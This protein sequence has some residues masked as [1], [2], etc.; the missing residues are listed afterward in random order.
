M[1][2]FKLCKIL[3]PVDFSPCSLAGVHYAARLAKTTGGTL[4]LLHVIFPYTQL[5]TTDRG[6]ADLIRL[7]TAAKATA[8][9]QMKELTKKSF[10]GD[11][12]CETEIRTGSVIDE[13]VEESSEPGV[14][15]IVTSTHG[16]TGLERAVI[17]SVAEHVVR[18]AECPVL[19]V[20]SGGCP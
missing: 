8:R 12:P 13:I 9:E 16:R 14:D 20:P 15:L 10:L 18:Y 2:A 17:G 19:T 4:R 6:G 7:S 11:I 5:F 3:V 1:S